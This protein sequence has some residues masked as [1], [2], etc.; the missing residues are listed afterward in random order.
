MNA[1][2]A[3]AGQSIGLIK[4]VLPVEQI[5]NQTMKEFNSVCDSLSNSKFEL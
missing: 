5:I 4:E 2:P 3:L 1:A